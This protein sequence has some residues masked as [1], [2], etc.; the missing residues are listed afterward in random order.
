VRGKAKQYFFHG[1]VFVAPDR[2]VASSD[3]DVST[4]E[5]AGV[6]AF[7]RESGR[8]LWKHS[9]GKGVVGAVIAAGSR[10]FMYAATGDL[11]ALNLDSGTLAW[12]N[13]L[14][15][16]AWESPA[17]VGARV[18]A[19][20]SDGSASAFN[21]ET[22]RVEW[23]QKLGAA[24]STSA[25]ATD[26]DVYLG[27]ADGT[28]Y[29]LSAANGDVRSSVEIDPALTPISAPVPTGNDVLVLLADRQADYRALVAVDRSV[30]QVT[31]RQA[32]PERWTT[33]RVFIAERTVWLGTPSG[34]VMAYCAA[35]GR[36]AWSH[37]LAD[38]PIRSIGGSDGILYVGTA[39]GTLYA[40]RPPT[41]CR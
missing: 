22:G 26:S 2:I 38:A 32:A 21:A 28:M 23:Q 6:H 25:L 4:G 20:S 9:A 33:S 7:D 11:L 31:W 37:K 8:E 29:R 34:E 15:A 1:D 30:S 12:S 27:T 35:D 16:S 19:G 24:V 18:V 14:K 40:I 41:L 3:V 5:V 39:R 17:V 13:P 10:A 36:H